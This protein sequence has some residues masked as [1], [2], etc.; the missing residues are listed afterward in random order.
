VKADL[1]SGAY[2]WIQNGRKQL[3]RPSD[4][5]QWECRV[6]NLLPSKF[7]RYAKILHHLEARY[8]NID[9]PLTKREAAIVQ[10]PD[11]SLV[12][13]FVENRRTASSSSRFRWKEIADWMSVPFQAEINHQWFAERLNP[14]PQCWPRFI[15]GP[16]DGS[17]DALERKQVI[18]ILTPFTPPQECFFRFAEQ[19]FIATDAP[20]VFRGHLEQLE[21]F[22]LQGQYQFSPEYWWPEDESWCMCS[23]YDL[24]FT[25]AGG[26]SDLIESL[27]Q[28][29][30]LE[31]L[32]VAVDTR[33][34]SLVPMPI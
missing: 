25:V 34:D 3:V 6:Q 33:V 9:N 18:S 4:A 5:Q 26:R 20:L 30:A 24:K 11:C 1:T 15:W 32:E 28:N 14:N 10:L 7:E 31:T 2:E 23:D 12:R 29:E 22:L 27:L 19:P 8:E 17:L 21:P 16:A 13:K